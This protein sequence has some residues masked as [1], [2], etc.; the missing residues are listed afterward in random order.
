MRIIPFNKIKNILSKKIS[1]DL[2]KKI[3]KGKVSTYGAISQV[4][5]IHPRAVGKILNANPDP[6]GAPCYKIIKSD[7][8]ESLT[9]RGYK[10]R[11]FQF[12]STLFYASAP[13]TY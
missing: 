6:V 13:T 1:A 10:G 7:G 9:L 3:P 5:G 11:P 2:I 12:V 4:T 8:K